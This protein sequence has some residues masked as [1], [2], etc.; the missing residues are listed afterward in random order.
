LQPI[1]ALL[2]FDKFEQYD[3]VAYPIEKKNFTV[4]QRTTP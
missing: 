2:K 3:I 4:R 1:A